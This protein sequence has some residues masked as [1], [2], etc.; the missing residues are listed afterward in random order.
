[1]TVPLLDQRVAVVTG[2]DQRIRRETARALAGHGAQVASADLHA[3]LAKAAVP[4][5][6]A[7]EPAEVAGAV[8][9]L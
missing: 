7:Y 8:V 6:R 3:D 2:A 5:R 4:E 1:M 9:S